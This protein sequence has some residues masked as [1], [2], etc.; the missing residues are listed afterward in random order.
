[1][2]TKPQDWNGEENLKERGLDAEVARLRV[3][4]PMREFEGILRRMEREIPFLTL[5]ADRRGKPFLEAWIAWHFGRAISAT[6]ARLAPEYAA[7]D[8]YLKRRGVGWQPWQATEAMLEGRQRAKELRAH[9]PQHGE[10]RHVEDDEILRESAGA[11]PAIIKALERKKAAGGRLAIYW[12]TGW[13][14]GAGAV[15]E[16]LRA[17]T[18]PYRADF[19]EAW[20]MGSS[21][22]FR[23][24]PDFEMVKGPPAAFT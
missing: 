8:F 12:N 7:D 6:H 4:R 23:V 1:M 20:I 22:L 15:I 16:G 2:R 24:A 3:G 10:V 19:E 17:Q 11:L 9:I 13:L 14:R 21:S 18:E 5:M